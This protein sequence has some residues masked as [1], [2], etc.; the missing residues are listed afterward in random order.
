M[1]ITLVWMI[2]WPHVAAQATLISLALVVAQPLDTVMVIGCG[3]DPGASEWPLAV[4]RARDINPEH[5]HGTSMDPDMVLSR[6]LGQAVIMALRGC[7]GPPR[8]A[9]PL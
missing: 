1:T 8:L 7:A 6:R 5:G 3:P 9:W 2:L 4:T